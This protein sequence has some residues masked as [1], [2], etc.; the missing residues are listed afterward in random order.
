MSYCCILDNFNENIKLLKITF[1]DFAENYYSNLYFNRKI[2]EDKV[3]E[4]YEILANNKYQIPWTC[5]SINDIKNNKKQLIDGQHR[6]EAIIKYLDKSESSKSHKNNYIYMWEYVI[7]DINNHNSNK[8]ALDLFKKLNNNSP[9]TEDDMPKNKIVEV[10]IQLKKD[11]NLK[12]GIGID[13][14]HKSCNSPK[15]HEKELFELLNKHE[16]LFSSIS[17]ETIISNINQINTII[18]LLPIETLYKNKKAITDKEQKTKEKA[19]TL[20]FYLGIKD[21]AIPPAYWIKYLIDPI[22]LI[23]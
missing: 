2:N 23:S 17:V 21:S 14:K 18:S 7:D 5:H 6:H 4:L 16:Y 22:S 12:A 11:K 9:L 3:A 20:D 10:L 8:Y 13:N 15:I 1:K 19:N